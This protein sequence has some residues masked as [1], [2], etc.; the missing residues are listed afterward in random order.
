MGATSQ[1]GALL[2]EQ[3][4]VL[5]PVGGDEAPH[6]GGADAAVATLAVRI[7]G[8]RAAALQALAAPIAVADLC[9]QGWVLAAPVIRLAGCDPLAGFT[10][11]GEPAA[12]D[13]EV[14]GSL[15]H[16]TGRAALGYS[17]RP[18]RGMGLG[19]APGGG[20]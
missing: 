12:A 5:G 1:P 15:G 11:G 7:D 17:R 20:L 8:G 2:A 14:A 3:G 6:G 16:L 10:V 4:P 18:R 9:G 19:S 13:V